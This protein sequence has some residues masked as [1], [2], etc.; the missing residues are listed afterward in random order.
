MADESAAFVRALH[1]AD[2]PGVTELR[3]ITSDTARAVFFEQPPDAARLDR[4]MQR[5]NG[6]NLYVGVAKR[7]DRTSGKKENCAGLYALF[8]DLD[9]STTPEA[10]ARKRLAE[11]PLSPSAIVA[12]GGGLHVYWFL[13]EPLDAVTE[14]A[15]AEALLRRLAVYLGGDL[16]CAEVAR[17]LRLPGT[18]NHKYP[19]P[20]AVVLEHLEA[21]QAYNVSDFDEWLPA[22][23]GKP[24]APDPVATADGDTIPEGERHQTLMRMLGA[25]RR[26]GAIEADLRALAESLNRRMVPPYPAHELERDLRSAAGFVPDPTIDADDVTLDH[27]PAAVTSPVIVW[28][29]AREVCSAAPPE[30]EL[31]VAPYFFAGATTQI[32]ATPK[33]GKSTFRNYFIRCALRGRSSLG[34]PAGEPTPVVLATEEPEAVLVESLARRRPGRARRPALRHPVRRARPQVAGRRHGD[35]RQ[36]PG[37]RRPVRLDRH[38]LGARQNLRRRGEQGRRRAGRHATAR[39]TDR[40]QAR[41]RP[42]G[43]RAER[44]RRPGRVRPWLVGLRRRRGRARV[45]EGREGP[46]RDL[47]GAARHRPLPLRAGAPD[48]RADVPIPI[49]YSGLREW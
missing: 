30:P 2:T 37:S 3:A 24:K 9:F 46:P 14:Q 11:C 18:L 21:E 27:A 26:E 39:R 31:I 1:P 7:R 47:P 36:V 13:I 48:R 33:R 43:A 6:A 28:R 4:L 10:D 38:A 35:R 8:V 44:R 12:S 42:R 17:V 32:E 40:G 5:A 19:P 22:D 23:P 29:T 15:K 45:H 41:R 20:R 16:A 49:P 25:A 34:F